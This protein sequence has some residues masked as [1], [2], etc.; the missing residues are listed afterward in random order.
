MRFRVG[1][2][3]KPSK[4]EL[5]KYSRYYKEWNPNGNAGKVVWIN[6]DLFFPIKVMWEKSV[7]GNYS[8]H[9]LRLYKR[10]N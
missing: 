2:L 7:N 4:E 5:K 1:D 6:E 3:V 9:E 8:E 10:G